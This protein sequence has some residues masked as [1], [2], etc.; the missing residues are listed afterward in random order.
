MSI[1]IRP[2]KNGG[3]EVDIA[4]RLPNGQRIR[5]RRKAPV[6]SR[7]GTRRWAEARELEMLQRGIVPAPAPK[8]P[9]LSEF[10]AQYMQSSRAD[11]QKHSTIMLKESV[12]R[13]WLVPH[14]GSK[15]LDQITT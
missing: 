3:Y 9:R 7:S 6:A 1:T 13:T 11:R 8:A 14:L 12:F 2:F 10:Q 4:I 15:R 5:E